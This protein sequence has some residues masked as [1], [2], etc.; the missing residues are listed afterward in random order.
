MGRLLQ[1]ATRRLTRT[2]GKHRLFRLL[3]LYPP[4]LGAGIRVTAV[5]KDL[6]TI[7]VAM[8]LGHLNQNYVGTQFGGS[9]YSMCDPFLMLILIE[10]LGPDFVVWD[11][12]AH[13]RFLK[14]GRG[15]VRARFEVSA[16]RIDE[17]RQAAEHG[18]V[19]PEF[20]V[21]VTDASGEAVARVHKTLYVR[22]KDGAPTSPGS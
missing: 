14:P 1:K 18:K 11:K 6:R 8:R 13:I 22:R 3:S 7:D 5:S 21:E 20:E 12:A 10:N 15:T 17:I 4:Y 2:V 16:E 9:L 19:E